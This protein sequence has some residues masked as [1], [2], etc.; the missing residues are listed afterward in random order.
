[1]IRLV[2]VETKADAMDEFKKI[3]FYNHLILEKKYN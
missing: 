1:M 3:A 2:T